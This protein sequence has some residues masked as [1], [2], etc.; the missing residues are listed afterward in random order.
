MI[1]LRN[2]RWG[3]HGHPRLR[4]RRA[5]GGPRLA[6]PECRLPEVVRIGGIVALVAAA[7]PALMPT[8]RFESSVRWALS[9]PLAIHRVWFAMAASLGVLIVYAGASS[10]RSLPWPS[11]S[12][13]RPQ[14]SSCIMASIRAGS[15]VVPQVRRPSS[16]RHAAW[17]MRGVPFW[18]ATV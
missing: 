10:R 11:M 5:S 6:A 13:R 1:Q 8:A 7:V 4:L 2:N 16:V 14:N 3:A 12:P 17:A 18:C 9:R 15:L